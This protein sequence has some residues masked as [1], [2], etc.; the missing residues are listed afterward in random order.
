MIKKVSVLVIVVVFAAFIVSLFFIGGQDSVEFYLV[1]WVKDKSNPLLDLG[2]DRVWSATTY[3]NGTF[4]IYL[5]HYS[6]GSDI[7]HWT[8]DTSLDF[9]ECDSSPV[10]TR[11]DVQVAWGLKDIPLALEPHS[12]VWW[13]DSWRLYFGAKVLHYYS[14]NNSRMKYAW[15]I[16]CAVSMD[17]DTWELVTSP[18]LKPTKNEASVADPHAVVYNGKIYLFY[19]ATGI[20]RGDEIMWKLCGAWSDDG[21]N[22]TKFGGGVTCLVFGAAPGEFIALDDGITGLIINTT[23]EKRHLLA[24]WTRDGQNLSF[25]SGN[26]VIS[27]CTHN[28]WESGGVGHIS[29]CSVDETFYGFYAGRDSEGNFRLGGVSTISVACEIVRKWGKDA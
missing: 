11:S 6:N 1:D 2:N 13:K 19:A 24:V 4:H 10:I 26:P 20:A 22:F 16:G 17:L 5:G 18:C 7:A 28:F 25:Y 12:I 27:P 8:S 29:I 14:V 23:A 21:D 15:W 9:K 3:F